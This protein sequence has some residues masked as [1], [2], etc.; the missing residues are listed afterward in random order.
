MPDGAVLVNTSRGGL[1]DLEALQDALAS[2]H[3]GGALDVLEEEP[4]AP[5]DPLL[6]RSDVIVTPHASFYS[7]ES[8]AELQ[9]KAAQQ[10]VE[11]LAGRVPPY[12]VN[13]AQLGLT[14][15]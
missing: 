5:D 1:V 9:R 14:R 2:G 3:I 11:A 4:P 8:V 6:A 15:L 7:E 10:V 12:A 13:A